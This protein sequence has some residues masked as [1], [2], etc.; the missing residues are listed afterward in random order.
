MSKN[1]KGLRTELVFILDASGSMSGLEDDTVGGFNAMIEENREE[2]GEATVSLVTFSTGSRVLLNRVP[3]DEVPPLTRKK[4]R[5]FGCTAL[6]DAVGSAIEHVD[7]VQNVQ[8]SG[9]KADK[10]LFVITTDG[11]ENA[12]KMYTYRRVRG[13]I[14]SHRELGWE[15][16]FVGANIDVELEADRLGIDRSR[17]VSYIADDYGTEAV[18]RSASSAVRAVRCDMPLEESAWR[19][20][21]DEDMRKRGGGR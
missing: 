1:E 18:Y 13:L 12:S 15:F 19:E 8:P 10:V 4:Y 16:V 2:P 7:L 17:A 6:L 3:I 20:E 5:C 9:F 11:M 21:L 14:E